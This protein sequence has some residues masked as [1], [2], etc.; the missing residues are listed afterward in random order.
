MTGQYLSYWIRE[1]GLA[2]LQHGCVVHSTRCSHCRRR[3]ALAP[4]IQRTTCTPSPPAR[5]RLALVNSCDATVSSQSPSHS[6]HFLLRVLGYLKSTA[7][8]TVEAG[9]ARI[10]EVGTWPKQKPFQ[11]RGYTL[12]FQCCPS[13][14][15]YENTCD[16]FRL[17]FLMMDFTNGNS[18]LRWGGREVRKLQQR[19]LIHQILTSRARYHKVPYLDIVFY[20]RTRLVFVGG[21]LR[22]Q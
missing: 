11:R 1:L 3:P 19:D 4:P 13:F 21:V 17:T 22:P 20:A 7:Q 16:L 10:V 5:P 15:C 14:V 2:P 12:S 6:L 9:T 18:R 8:G